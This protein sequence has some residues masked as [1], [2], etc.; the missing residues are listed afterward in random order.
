MFSLLIK[1]NTD[2]TQKEDYIIKTIIYNLNVLIIEEKISQS[3][4]YDWEI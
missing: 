2:Y 1:H 4:F 3:S